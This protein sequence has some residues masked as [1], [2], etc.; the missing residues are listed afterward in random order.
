MQMNS[1]K[2]STI[3]ALGVLAFLISLYTTSTG[4]GLAPDSYVYL[5]SAR[6]LLQGEGVQVPTGPNGFVHPA[7]FP[8]LFAGLLA[9]SSLTVVDPLESARWLN[10]IIFAANVILVFLTILKLTQ[11]AYLAAI[12]GALFALSSQGMIIIHAHVWS[13]PAFFFF[14]FLSLLLLATSLDDP[15]ERWWIGAAIATGLAFLTRYAG[16]TVVITGVIA[17]LWFPKTSLV[18]RIRKAMIFFGVSV[19]PVAIW[20]LIN[21]LTVGSLTNRGMSY[22]PIDLDGLLRG[23]STVADWFY[24]PAETSLLI[25]VLFLIST[26]LGLALLIGISVLALRDHQNYRGRNT[27]NTADVP[28]LLF[29]LIYI[30]FLLLSVSLFDAQTSLD[31][32]ILSPIFLSILVVVAA[33]LTNILAQAAHA[34]QVLGLLFTLTLAS[35][36]LLAGGGLARKVHARDYKGYNSVYWENLRLI[37]QVRDLPDSTPIY[38]NGHDV[39][40][41]LTGKPAIPIPREIS[42][43]SLRKNEAYVEEMQEMESALRVEGGVLVFFDA[44]VPRRWYLPSEEELNETLPLELR[45]RWG[46]EGALYRIVNEGK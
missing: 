27:K 46:N 15:Q 7:H 9:L 12:L 20:M 42:P 36:H 5:G 44:Q 45:T 26:S 16:V 43:N 37:Q 35:T 8:P 6:S 2:L 32:R 11:G 22:H 24:P 31:A 10:A 25:N 34:I 17:L 21:L 29:T 39:I 13:E 40:Y 30:V 1:W 18:K 41:L 33:R 3:A 19:L 4:A 28:F 23:L 14:S 38:S